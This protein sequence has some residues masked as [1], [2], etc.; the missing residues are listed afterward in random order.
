MLFT[1]LAIKDKSSKQAIV[2]T[3]WNE[4]HPPELFLFISIDHLLLKGFFYW[5]M[6]NT[7][8]IT[9]Y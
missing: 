7:Y 3:C 6:A 4:K 5:Y 2:V 1:L 9:T 8:K